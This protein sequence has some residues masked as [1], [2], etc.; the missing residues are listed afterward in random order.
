MKNSIYWKIYQDIFQLHKK[1]FL[2]AGDDD[3][4]WSNFIHDSGIIFKKYENVEEFSFVKDL[5]MALSDEV[6]RIYNL[7]EV[8]KNE[9]KT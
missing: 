4:Y 3:A 1:Y 6:E 5:L 9:Q 2:F 7:K 8:Q